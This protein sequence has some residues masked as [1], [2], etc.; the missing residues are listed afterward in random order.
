MAEW[1]H[2][3]PVGLRQRRTRHPRLVCWGPA[4]GVGVVQKRSRC[5][6]IRRVTLLYHTTDVADLILREGFTDRVGAYGLA[7]LELRGVFVSAFPANIS[8]GATGDHVLEV[9]L[10]DD[11]DL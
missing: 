6:T 3:F 11:L 5:A 9:T 2:P 4:G 10:P 7:T 8:D 1:G